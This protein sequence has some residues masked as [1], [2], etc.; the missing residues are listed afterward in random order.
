ML[1]NA[2]LT[3]MRADIADLMPDTCNILTV[4]RLPDGQGGVTDTWGT[5]TASVACRLD[6]YRGKEAMSGDALQAF[7]TYVL[8]VPH[9]TTITTASRVEHE[10]VTYNVTSVDEYK[11]WP[12]TRRAILERT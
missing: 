1:S 8:T 10:S 7:N 9:D 12:I 5:A 3:Q 2:E 6:A 11:S 4:T